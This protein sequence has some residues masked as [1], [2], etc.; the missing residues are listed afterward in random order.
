MPVEVRPRGYS[1]NTAKKEVIIVRPERREKQDARKTMERAAHR[2]RNKEIIEEYRKLQEEKTRP[3]TL[4]PRKS[5]LPA[6]R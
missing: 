2:K 6:P 4:Q 1:K 5:S 3:T